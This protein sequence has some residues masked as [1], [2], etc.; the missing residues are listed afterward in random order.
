MENN[1]EASA[2]AGIGSGPSSVVS[3]SPPIRGAEFER[4]RDLTSFQPLPSSSQGPYQGLPLEPGSAL[5]VQSRGINFVNQLTR[6]IICRWPQSLCP[7]G[8]QL[9]ST[10]RNVSYMECTRRYPPTTPS[11]SIEFDRR[12]P[13]SVTVELAL[14]SN[15]ILWGLCAIPDRVDS[16]LTKSAHGAPIRLRTAKE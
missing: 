16:N 15:R 7:A 13:H 12:C 1:P 2:K 8:L 10:M 14:W 6:L 9:P 11:S 3:S 4:P 5:H